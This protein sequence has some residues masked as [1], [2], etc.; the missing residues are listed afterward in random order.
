MSRAAFCKVPSDGEAKC[1][2]TF[3]LSERTIEPGES[4]RRII[5]SANGTEADTSSPHACFDITNAEQDHFMT[6]RLQAAREC[7]HRVYV[8]GA[9]KTECAKSGHGR[10]IVRR[11]SRGPIQVRSLNNSGL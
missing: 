1:L 4:A 8:A 2:E 3:F 9:C 6:A 5:A 11:M 10:S 7:S